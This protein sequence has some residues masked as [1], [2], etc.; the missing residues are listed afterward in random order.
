MGCDI[1]AAAAMSCSDVEAGGGEGVRD[2]LLLS[3][4]TLNNGGG[5]VLLIY[6]AKPEHGTALAQLA[7]GR[8]TSQRVLLFL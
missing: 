1:N 6:F 4:V 2:G 3:L 5:E 7:L 8:S